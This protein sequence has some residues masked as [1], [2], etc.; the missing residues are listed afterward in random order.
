MKKAIIIILTAAVLALAAVGFYHYENDK[1]GDKELEEYRRQTELFSG[2]KPETSEVDEEDKPEQPVDYLAESKKINPQIVAWV[3]IPDSEIDF[4]IVQCE[5]NEYYLTH[6]F[7]NNE[8]YMGAPFLDCRNNPDFSDFNSVIYGHNIS[9][10]YMFYPLLNFK[11]KDYFDSHSY[12]YLTLTDKKY[13]INFIACAVIESDGFAYNTVFL[14]QKEREVFLKTAKEKAV[15]FGNF[16]PEELVDKS[17]CTLSTC[18]YEFSGARTV[19]IGYR[20]EVT[21]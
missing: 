18:S 20:E 10:K 21:E 1:A 12:G 14:S 11:N 19:L 3:T 2:V 15:C 9:N 16:D 17:L 4:P 7:E 13:K 5:D 6:D 8:S